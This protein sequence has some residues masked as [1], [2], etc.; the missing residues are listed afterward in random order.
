MDIIEIHSYGGYLIDQ[1]M[2][3]MWNHR[4]DE[5]GGSLENR[6][7]FFRE[8]VEAVRKGVGP[9]D[10]YKRQLAKEAKAVYKIDGIAL[11]NCEIFEKFLESFREY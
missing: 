9:E 6:L 7:R 8:F 11:V 3:K 4:T 10:V 1:F 5:Y 2:S